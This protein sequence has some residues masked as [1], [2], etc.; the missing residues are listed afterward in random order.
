MPE[1]GDYLQPYLKEEPKDI[2]AFEKMIGREPE[3]DQDE[4]QD[5]E[6]DV[7]ILNPEKIGKRLADIDFGKQLG[8]PEP[9]VDEL[10]EELILEPNIDT[11]KP[12]VPAA[13]EFSKQLGRTEPYKLDD[14]EIFIVD[15]LENPIP[16]DPS[17]PR[18][19]GVLNFALQQDRFD[20]KEE[21]ARE[22]DF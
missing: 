12:K 1:H 10:H 14:N 3:R 15:F 21:H 4:E 11:I 18:V 2:V 13:P 22:N 8:R 16:N 20:R 7:L 6:G 5:V 19:K 17:L 9:K